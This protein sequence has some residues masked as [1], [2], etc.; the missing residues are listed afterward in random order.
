MYKGEK[1]ELDIKRTKNSLREAH[2]VSSTC[3]GYDQQHWKEGDTGA[4]YV[5]LRM[6]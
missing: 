5:I 4:I 2:S 1:N 3:V 6:F